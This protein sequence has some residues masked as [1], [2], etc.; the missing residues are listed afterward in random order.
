MRLFSAKTSVDLFTQLFQVINIVF[1]IHTNR[2]LPLPGILHTCTCTH[3]YKL[4][5]TWNIF[6]GKGFPSKHL[7]NGKKY[8]VAR[9]VC[10]AH[11]QVFC[12]MGSFK[13]Y[14]QSSIQNQATKSVHVY[15]VSIGRK[16][17]WS[18]LAWIYQ[19]EMDFSSKRKLSFLSPI[20]AD[21]GVTIYM[22]TF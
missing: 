22:C 2:L 18:F 5:H 3:A 19:Y 12:I 9:I 20:K 11:W 10:R 6:R 4:N 17:I 8:V 15:R 1:S 21:P 7:R 16:T 13:S 14:S